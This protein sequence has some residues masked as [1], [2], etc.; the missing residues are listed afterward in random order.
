MAE[1]VSLFLRSQYFSSNI[2]AQ[3]HE[4]LW[5]Y[6][7]CQYSLLPKSYYIL[8]GI[9]REKILLINE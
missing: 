8:C 5:F 7:Y 2:M 6:Q 1:N 9:N 3:K 4:C